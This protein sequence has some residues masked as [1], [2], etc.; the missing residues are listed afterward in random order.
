MSCMFCEMLERGN[1]NHR[2]DVWCKAKKDYVDIISPKCGSFVSLF[3]RGVT[4]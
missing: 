4:K 1:S 3:E 2:G